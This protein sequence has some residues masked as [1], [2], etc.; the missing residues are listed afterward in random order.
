MHQK[1]IENLVGLEAQILL[2]GNRE[3][4][5]SKHHVFFAYVF[6]SILEGFGAGFG[7]GLGAPWRLLGHF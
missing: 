4:N 5:A 7:R 3:K 1:I 2:I 6:Q